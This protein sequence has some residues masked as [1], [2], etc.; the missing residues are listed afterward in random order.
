MLGK[1]SWNATIRHA[2]HHS[3]G[4]FNLLGKISWNAATTT[5]CAGFPQQSKFETN[6]AQ[7]SWNTNQYCSKKSLERII[8]IRVVFLTRLR[9]A[10]WM[11]TWTTMWLIWASECW[12]P[13]VYIAETHVLC[14]YLSNLTKLTNQIETEILLQIQIKILSQKNTFTEPLLVSFWMSSNPWNCRTGQ[15]LNYAKHTTKSK[16]I[17]MVWCSRCIFGHTWFNEIMNHQDRKLRGH[18]CLTS[19]PWI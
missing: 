11:W 1:I 3:S 9:W 12:R 13:C 8:T 14:P 7:C 17:A 2:K 10:S 19:H 5:D 18:S 16:P 6:A 4:D 15:L